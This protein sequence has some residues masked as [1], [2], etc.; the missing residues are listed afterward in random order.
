MKTNTEIKK[1]HSA[2]T[3]VE[4]LVSISILATVSI[5][6]YVS[7]ARHVKVANNA[8]RIETIDSLHLS[9][10]D[11]YQ[12]KKTLPEPNSNYISYDDK[13]TYM[14]SL[15]GAYG[16]SGYVSNNFLPSGYVNFRATDPESN[17]YYGYGKLT[18]NTSFD[19]AAA[20][21]DETT[22]GYKAYVRGTYPKERLS[23]LIRSYSSSNFVSQDSTEDLPYNPYERKVSAT[24]SSY[25]GTVKVTDDTG[26]SLSL[27]GELNSGDTI[28]VATGSTALLHISDGSELSLGSTTSETILELTSLKYSDD[29]NL[30]SKVQLLLSLGEVWTEAP[31]LRTETDSES[32]FSIQTDSAVAAVRGT[33]FGVSRSNTGETAL[34]LASGKLE[35]DKII[36]GGNPVPFTQEFF[37]TATEGFVIDGSQ[38]YM[39]VTDENHPIKLDGIIVDSPGLIDIAPITPSD[40]ENKIQRP[41]FSLGYRPKAE[42][43]SFTRTTNKQAS[44]LLGTLAVMFYNP[45]A[46]SYKLS[47]GTGEVTDNSNP[48]P[49]LTGSLTPTAGLITVTGSFDYIYNSTT[50]DSISLPVKRTY[51]LRICYRGQCSAPEIKT[52]VGAT[53]AFDNF[54]TWG[55]RAKICTKNMPIFCE[56]PNLVAYAPYDRLGDFKMYRPGSLPLTYSSGGYLQFNSA[57]SVSGVIVRSS[58]GFLKYDIDSLDLGSNFSIE[59]SVRGSALKRISTTAHL[60]ALGS[61][62]EYLSQLSFGIYNNS[63][64]AIKGANTILS[65]GTQSSLSFIILDKFYTLKFNF[66]ENGTKI[67]VL[68][69]GTL[70]NT[71]DISGWNYPYANINNLKVGTSLNKINAWGDT[72]NYVKIYK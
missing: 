72:I 27:T 64:I 4:L 57:N 18:D 43:I 1:R 40:I 13:G 54:K 48:N 10:S 21:Y 6:A 44:H 7:Y 25:S 69:D 56:E 14:H 19:V 12:M 36:S 52:L 58:S 63:F 68:L 50:T 8:T 23:S 61:N 49:V 42:S 39:V 22:G 59:M 29:N 46:D 34:S 71:L 9:L 38:S 66:I 11:Y 31:H 3:L 26:A 32:D 15:T 2:F 62:E 51:S 20:L 41:P 45:G 5:V 67:Q 24:V 30:A 33:V 17:Q 28:T 65:I 37:P 70:L 47:F 53:F 16:V 60:F 35:V 55:E